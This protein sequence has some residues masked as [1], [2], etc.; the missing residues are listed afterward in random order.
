[1]DPAMIERVSTDTGEIYTV[2]SKVNGSDNPNSIKRPQETTIGSHKYSHLVRDPVTNVVSSE[3]LK[4]TPIKPIKQ[5]PPPTAYSQLQKIDRKP[6][7]NI[8]DKHLILTPVN[9]RESEQDNEM[10]MAVKWQTLQPERTDSMSSSSQR[11]SSQTAIDE[12]GMMDMYSNISDLATGNIFIPQQRRHSFTEGDSS[13]IITSP[14]QTKH[15]GD[16][17]GDEEIYTIPPDANYDN[18]YSVVDDD[19]YVNTGAEELEPPSYQNRE[20]VRRILLRQANARPAKVITKE[21]PPSS[22]KDMILEGL[23]FKKPETVTVIQ[24]TSLTQAEKKQ[25]L[26]MFSFS[27]NNTKAKQLQIGRGDYEQFSLDR[28]N[29]RPTGSNNKRPSPPN[30]P[31]D[32]PPIR[33]KPSPSPGTNLSPPA[34]IRINSPVNNKPSA[35]IPFVPPPSISLKPPASLNSSPLRDRSSSNMEYVSNDK[36]KAFVRPHLPLSQVKSQPLIEPPIAK[37]QLPP[38]PVLTNGKL[39]MVTY[40]D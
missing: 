2:V 29:E 25:T 40:C 11:S 35:K 17:N 18:D 38:T 5:L 28:W 24:S 3:K 6:Y 10:W 30:R 1:M 16:D 15:N 22:V 14:S 12:L 4:K 37:K 20:E 7:D 27:D 19:D 9:R 26:G 34:I 13:I 21:L 36:S 32:R 23:R 8:E 39:I 31:P 33:P